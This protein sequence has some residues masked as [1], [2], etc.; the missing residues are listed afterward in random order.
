[1]TWLIKAGVNV[2]VAQGLARHSTPTLT[3][4]VYSHLEVIDRMNALDALPELPAVRPPASE[5]EALKATGTSDAAPV[6]PAFVPTADLTAPSRP[7]GA[8]RGTNGRTRRRAVRLRK[9]RADRHQMGN[10]RKLARRE[11]WYPQGES[12][13]CLQ[14]ESLLS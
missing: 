14:N 8:R 4:D 13:P 6:K 7:E 3:L 2:K 1:M 12:N 10:W 11:K 9:D 5:A